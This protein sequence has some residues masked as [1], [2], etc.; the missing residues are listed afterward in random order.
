MPYHKVPHRCFLDESVQKAEPVPVQLRFVRIFLRQWIAR[1][2]ASGS[3]VTFL[4]RRVILGVLTHEQDR[5]N[6]RSTP[7]HGGQIRIRVKQSGLQGG[8]RRKSVRPCS[9][10]RSCVDCRLGGEVS[11]AV[12]LERLVGATV[13]CRAARGLSLPVTFSRSSVKRW[14]PEK[15]VLDGLRVWAAAESRRRPEL[16]A[17]G[18]FGSY[19]RGEA[20]FGSDLDLVAIVGRSSVPFIERA[21]DWPLEPCR[22]R[23]TCWSTPPANGKRCTLAAVA[24]PVCWR[25]RRCG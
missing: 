4:V 15:V 1:L 24:S 22:C 6:M 12:P 8:G 18:Y 10:H 14:P 5:N 19:A 3:H 25:R 2:P 11:H 13:R 16:T 7:Q 17:L 23:P 21:R 9:R 20:G